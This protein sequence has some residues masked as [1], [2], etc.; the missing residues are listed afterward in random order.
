VVAIKRRDSNGSIP[1]AAAW[2]RRRRR[3]EEP[4]GDD[5]ERDVYD[6]GAK[7]RFQHNP[8]YSRDV[9]AR[10]CADQLS[11]SAR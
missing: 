1:Q 7:N 6:I 9:V 11:R 10:V 4:A 5:D 3:K 2:R 8:A